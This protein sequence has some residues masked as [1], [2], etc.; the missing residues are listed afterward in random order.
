MRPF[1]LLVKPA[2]G[3]CNLR[4]KYCFYLDR[5]EMYPENKRHRMSEEVLDRLISSFMA[6]NQPQ[7]SIGWQGGEPTLMGL[8]FFEK[9]TSLQQ[10]YARPGASVSNG[11]QTNTTLIDDAWAKHLAK[12]NFL[13]G[14]SIDGPREVH[15]KYRT[16]VNGRGSHADVMRGLECL[17]RNNVEY[18]VLTLVSQS[19]V[20]RPIE[21]YHYLRDEL[22]VKFHQYIE[23]VEFESDGSLQPFA[24]TGKEWGDF[25]CAVYDEW[26]R[27]GDTCNISI[28][29]F[30][31]ILTLMVDGYANVRA[32]GQNCQS[33]LVV[34]Y[35]GDVHPCDFYVRPELKLGN[36]M[37]DSWEALL[38]SPAYAAFGARKSPW[39]EK[40]A[41]CPYLQYC[42][43]CCP[44][45]RPAKGQ[46]PG[47]LSWLCDGWI[48]FFEHAVPKLEFLAGD[49]R[50]ERQQAALKM[51]SQPP[52]APPPGKVSRNDP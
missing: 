25:L 45:N 40:C 41:E 21:T 34:E 3:D 16:F 20:Q 11:L 4:C 43:G 7:H 5:C 38:D 36:I 44:N 19:N 2:S 9:V 6:T 27:C 24:V 28:R 13:V 1:S 10:Q 18:N 37:E 12:F 33:Y 23:C 17:K 51:R 31:S 14:V 48:Q 26:V 30:D 8:E 50:R 49:V 22:G 47:Q 35:N 29:L 46:D 32:T 39:S 52:S 15:D 42:A